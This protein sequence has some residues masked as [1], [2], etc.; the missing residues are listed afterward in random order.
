MRMQLCLAP[1]I[2]VPF[3]AAACNRGG[4]PPRPPS[5]PVAQQSSQ[6]PVTRAGGW[7]AAPATSSSSGPTK[8]AQ[9]ESPPLAATGTT[10]IRP[11]GG[12]EMVAI[13]R[14]AG[15]EIEVDY[16]A[17]GV[18][19]HLRGTPKESGKRKYTIDNGPTMFEV[20]PGD[21]GF[22]LRMADGKL[23]WKVKLKGEKIT[24]A[25]NEESSNPFVLR[26]ESDGTRILGPTGSEIGRVEPRAGTTVVT[27]G[28]KDVFVATGA[29]H[30]T[31]PG[32]LLM[33]AIP[34]VQQYMLIA[35]LL[36]RS[37]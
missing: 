8:L 9:K 21:E 6:P 26:P 12:A 22:K 15:G 2:V 11:A 33:D 14:A 31:A 7:Q 4:E 28:G 24:I 20:K 29:S 5:Q 32:V 36:A 25:D 17:D 19:H 23:R 34:R 27:A 1:L 3:I 30:S 10:A 18:K 16:I 37:R 35:E 13:R